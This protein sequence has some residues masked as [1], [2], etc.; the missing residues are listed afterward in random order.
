MTSLQHLD[1]AHKR[2]R[3]I[4]RVLWIILFLN[5]LVALAKMAWGYISHSAAMQADGIHSLFDGTSNIIA[6]VG[7]SIAARPADDDHPYGHSKFENY[8]SV[9]IGLML[10]FAA[11]TIG[12]QGIAGLMGKAKAL[13]VSGMSFAVMIITLIINI[14]VASYERKVGKRLNSDILL[15]DSSHTA[16][17]ILVSLGVIVSLV[18]AKFGFTMADSIVSLIIAAVIFYTAWGVFKQANE[19]LSDKARLPIDELVAVAHSVNGAIAAHEV[20]TRGSEAEVYLDMHLVVDP[21]ITV[22]QGHQ[23]SHDVEDAIC[24]AFPQVVDITIHVE[25]EGW[26]FQ[27]EDR[28]NFRSNLAD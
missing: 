7:L 26:E 28:T 6:L 23:I 27:G 25:P 24:K 17:D 19:T 10:L 15:A 12:S 11:Y 8:A 21:N 3:E 13:E 16:S 22:L 5:V 14:G 1:N 20:R 4:R 18:L 9:V 2:M